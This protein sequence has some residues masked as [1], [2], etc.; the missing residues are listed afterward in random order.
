MEPH[1]PLLVVE[2]VKS[3]PIKE[4][5]IAE[6]AEVQQLVEDCLKA[7]GKLHHLECDENH[8]VNKHLSVVC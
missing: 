7:R 5:V 4:M 8:T 2:S 3:K 6:N 1:F